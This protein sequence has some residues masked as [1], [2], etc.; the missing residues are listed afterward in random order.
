MG[1]RQSLQ[2]GTTPFYLQATTFDL[3]FCTKWHDWEY[4]YTVEKVYLGLI[5]GYHLHLHYLNKQFSG[6]HETG[7]LWNGQNLV[8]KGPRHRIQNH[9]VNFKIYN[10]TILKMT[11]LLLQT[12]NG[13]ITYPE[14]LRALK[15]NCK[16]FLI[17]SLVY[18]F[19]KKIRVYF[20]QFN[21][22]GVIKGY[23]MLRILTRI[24]SRKRSIYTYSL[25]ATFLT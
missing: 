2:V 11:G 24:S 12:I 23:P 22:S 5:Y 6:R 17:L 4:L 18:L 20:H 3:Q 25:Y 7:Y 8:I 16:D 13:H 19:K 14:G 15:I 10:I 1:T 21:F 9:E